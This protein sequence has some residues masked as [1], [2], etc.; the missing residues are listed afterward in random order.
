M[1]FLRMIRTLSSEVYG[2]VNKENV[3]IGRVDLHF[4]ENG[5]VS[6]LVT[7]MEEMS[8]EE[9][10]TLCERIDDEIV[11]DKE[12]SDDDFDITF[13]QARNVNIYGSAED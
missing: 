9:E 8:Q 13:V 4:A 5:R 11:S 2:I 7:T 10:L 12:L 6:G 3:T 1:R